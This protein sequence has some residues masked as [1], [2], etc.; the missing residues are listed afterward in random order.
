VV[1]HGRE[2]TNLIAEGLTL[3]V[4]PVP[5]GEAGNAEFVN[6]TKTAPQFAATFFGLTGMHMLHVTL[7]V[8][9]L[10]SSL[11]DDGSFQSCWDCGWWLGWVRLLIA[12][13]IT[14]RTYYWSRQ[15]SSRSFS[16]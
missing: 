14:A 7:G 13:S 4:F 3:P 16:G 9:Y 1:L 15:S 8:V 10:V 5:P 6:V 12:H 2:W 11:C